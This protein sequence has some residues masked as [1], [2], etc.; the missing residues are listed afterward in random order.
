[1]KVYAIVYD[2]RGY[3]EQVQRLFAVK[4]VAIQSL[5]IDDGDWC[6][7][8]VIEWDTDTQKQKRVYRGQVKE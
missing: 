3:E 7:Y 5:K 1:M 8:C 4:E 6:E 2:W